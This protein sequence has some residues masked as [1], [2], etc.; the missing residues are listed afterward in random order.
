MASKAD[1]VPRIREVLSRSGFFCQEEGNLHS[2]FFDIIARRDDQLV[3]LKVLGNA[4]SFKQEASQQLMVI[5]RFLDASP[6]LLGQRSGQGELED[7]VV[8]LRYGVPLMTPETFETLLIEGVPPF[9]FAGP[10][11]FYVDLD[12]EI[13]R[14]ERHRRNISLGDLATVAGV[15]RKAIQNYE[16]GCSATIDAASRLEE[17]LEIPLVRALDPFDLAT[18]DGE[19]EPQDPSTIDEFSDFDRQVLSSLRNA[20]MDIVPTVR[21]PFKSLTVSTETLFL[22]GIERKDPSVRRTARILSSISS[23]TERTSFLVMDDTSRESIEGTP[24]VTSR[25]LQHANSGECLQEM[26]LE[27]EPRAYSKRVR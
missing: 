3:V 1:I 22:T 27:R 8:Y 13:I 26:L 12:G 18:K 14:E 7:E 21:C 9:I 15:S 19:I 4:D 11:G 6:L 10:G 25:E 20:G 24:V 2:S 16:R 5:S 17:F 23:V